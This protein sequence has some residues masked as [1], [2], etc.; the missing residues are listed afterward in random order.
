VL[1]ANA[2]HL[3]RGLRAFVAA[4]VAVSTWLVVEVAVF[5]S[6]YSSR[7]E[8]RNLFYLAPLFL[9]ALLA[10]IERG[11][12]RPP[13]AAIVAAG[14]AAALPGAIPFVSLLDIT[15]QS[16]TLGLQPWWYLGDAWAGRDSVAV[17]V[18]ADRS[19][20]L[21]GKRVAADPAKQLVLYRLNGPART[22]TRIGGLYQGAYHP[23]SGP[24]LTWE[25]FACTGGTLSVVVESDALLFRGLTQT[26]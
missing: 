12:P 6:Q 14:L 1:L 3:D 17:V 15:A 7:I 23:W 10:W 22:T 8:E 11:Q 5:A 4:V 25:R 13:R 9:I 24:R 16:D 21:L 18:L 19:L 2:R 26:V 20:A